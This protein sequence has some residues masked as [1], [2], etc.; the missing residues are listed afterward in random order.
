MSSDI[1]NM[2]N[3]DIIEELRKIVKSKGLKYTQQREI[4]LSIL[5]S[6]KDHLTA[7]DIYN[8]FKTSY[9]DQTIG[10]ATVYRALAFLEEIKLISSISI[11][12]SESKKYESNAK[13]HH[14]HL[15]CTSCNKIIEFLDD[16]IEKRQEYI[17]TKNRFKI[18]YHS[19]QLYGLCSD[20]Q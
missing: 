19:M 6:E 3:E 15:I 8:N 13:E 5:I 12:S 18:T 7:E 4:I 14:D 10:I 9:P 1:S 20:C 16:D 17:A 11:G 2:S